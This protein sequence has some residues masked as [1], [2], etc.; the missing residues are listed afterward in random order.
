MASETLSYVMRLLAGWDVDM[1]PNRTCLRVVRE[2]TGGRPTLGDRLRQA[3]T[4]NIYLTL[5]EAA[6]MLNVEPRDLS[7]WEN[8]RYV[9]D[10]SFIDNIARLHGVS[11]EWLRTGRHEAH[12]DAE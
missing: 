10:P 6:R 8:D 5:R 2:Q 9:P 4:G 11:A 3:R 12:H 7:A 1:D